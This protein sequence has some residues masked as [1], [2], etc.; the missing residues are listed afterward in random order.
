MDFSRSLGWLLLNVAVPFLAPI[1]LLPLLGASKKYNGRVSELVRKSLQEGQ[2][3]WTVIAVC[4]TAS[5]EA[6]VHL[7]E[8]KG[9][10]ADI[11]LSITIAWTI[12][13]WHIVII[14][15][16]AVL[17]LLGAMDAADEEVHDATMLASS[18]VGKAPRIMMV[19]IWMSAA[20]TVSYTVT[21]LWAS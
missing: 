16:S 4:A 19:S 17:V 5:Y 18:G 13:I 10:V 8:L 11:S 21:H 20:T 2:L 6:A 12:I 3:F 9:S 1:A 15:I 7:G 14:I